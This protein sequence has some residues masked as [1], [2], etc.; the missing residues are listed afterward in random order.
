MIRRTEQRY[1]IRRV[2]EHTVRPLTPQ[3]VLEKAK[4]TVPGLGIATVYRNLKVLHQDGILSTVEVPGAPARYEMANRGHRHHFQCESCNRVFDM[5]KSSFTPS[6][7]VPENFKV[8][9]HQVLFYGF[10]PECSH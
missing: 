1:A 9:D 10:C 7:L 6:A 5:P 4:A 3:E 8:R 2:L